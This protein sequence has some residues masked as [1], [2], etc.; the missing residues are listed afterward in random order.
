VTREIVRRLPGMPEGWHNHGLALQLSGDQP[1]AAK[2][3]R[4]ALSID[5]ADDQSRLN[6][7]F[8]LDRRGDRAGAV[9][10]LLALVERD[11]GHADA[12]WNLAA[13]A[14]DE[15]EW[16]NARLAASRVVE[17]EP[18]N[19]QPPRLLQM[20]GTRTSDGI[21]A[22]TVPR[23]EEARRRFEAGEVE[24]AVALLKAAAWLDADAPLPHHYLA[25]IYFTTG[26]RQ[27]ALAHEREA[28]ARAPD[29]P[30]YQRNVAAL[31]GPK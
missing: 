24:N 19:P 10:L 18:R 2:A 16:A 22:A 6:L 27:L 9:E 7:A 3:Y 31:G 29:N 1:G 13:I 20:L 23:T 30:L 11:P 28:L 17:L 25:N 4:T 21:D 12:W 5:P 15:Q 26:R 14:F 8:L